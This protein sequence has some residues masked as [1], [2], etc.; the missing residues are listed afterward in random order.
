MKI[1]IYILF[2]FNLQNVLSQEVK[3]E[4]S[5]EWSK[6]KLNISEEYDTILHPYLCVKYINL[7]QDSIYIPKTIYG[8]NELPLV[9]SWEFSFN[10][11]DYCKNELNAI[12][13]KAVG[14]SSVGKYGVQLDQFRYT[15]DINEFT[16]SEEIES[17]SFYNM[18]IEMIHKYISNKNNFKYFAENYLINKADVEDYKRYIYLNPREVFIDK[19]D[20]IAFFILRGEYV[21]YYDKIPCNTTMMDNVQK[22]YCFPDR[23]NG[24]RLYCGSVVS[25]RLSV[26]F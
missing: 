24:Y 20:L 1:I 10:N 9:L 16:E 19:F 14:S 8:C 26:I 3:I 17:N 11:I 15:L 5:L 13:Q 7:T 25:D 23:K 22:F 12:I 6:S 18:R 21:F 2:L 4:L